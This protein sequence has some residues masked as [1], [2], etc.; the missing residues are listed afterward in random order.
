MNND[1]LANNCG[2]SIM[3]LDLSAALNTLNHRITD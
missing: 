1:I 2:T 3:S